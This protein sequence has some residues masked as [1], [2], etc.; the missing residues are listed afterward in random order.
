MTICEAIQK[1][2]EFANLCSPDERPYLS[3]KEWAELDEAISLT[4]EALDRPEI[5]NYL[6]C[7]NL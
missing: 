7:A 1:L 3:K 2:T 6:T 4:R 5:H